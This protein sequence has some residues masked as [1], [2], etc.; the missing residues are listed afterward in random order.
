MTERANGMNAETGKM[1]DAEAV[2]ASAAVAAQAAPVPKRRKG[3]RR[4]LMAAVPLALVLAGGGYWLT[5]GR[6]VTTD[7]AYVHQPMIPV[8]ADVSGRITEVDVT[9]NQQIAA[10]AP[11]F[12]LDPEPYRIAVA[13][14]EAALA[15]AR[16]AV[17]QQRA[18]YATAEAQLEAARSILEVQNREQER[19][20]ALVKRGVNSAASLDDATVA[21][22]N[23]SNDVAIARRQRDAA[24]AALGGDP[25]AQTDD[26]PAVRAA[27]ARLDA[28]RRDLAKTRID[29][30]V[31][32]TVA[33]VGSLNV[34]QFVQAGSGIAT[35]VDANDTWI[36]ANFKETQ[37]QG[38]RTGQ[39]V[40]VELDAYPDLELRGKVGSIGAATGSQFSL[41]PAQNA[42]G[43]WVKVV[44]RL[45]VRIQLDGAPAGVLR[46]GFSARVSIDTGKSRLDQLR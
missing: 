2:P 12:R 23:A 26:L 36:E 4:M 41:I 28:A 3:R 29:A 40:S 32:G 45:P 42:T 13:Q 33:Q 39:P 9:E 24:A 7:N 16:L 17:E 31:S 8:S 21:T 6:Y 19:R 30:P 43:N 44:Q 27:I 35:L 46:N 15:S 38:I 10:G 37:L 5:G 14:A 22:R 25:T 34:G 18:A 1:K 20:Q 11:I